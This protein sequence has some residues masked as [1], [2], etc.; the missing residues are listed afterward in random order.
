MYKQDVILSQIFF[1]KWE[2]NDWN[3]SCEITDITWKNNAAGTHVHPYIHPLNM[4]PRAIAKRMKKGGLLNYGDT[5]RT[6]QLTSQTIPTLSSG[7]RYCR[8]FMMFLQPCH[9]N[10]HIGSLP[11]LSN[12]WS[13]CNWH[14]FC[15]SIYPLWEIVLYWHTS[16]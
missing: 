2:V 10:I 9:S 7:G 16:C 5:W 11:H 14:A 12:P 3:P 13:H 6:C 1:F 4:K 8:L 15:T